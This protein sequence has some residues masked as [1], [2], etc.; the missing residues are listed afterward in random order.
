[1]K[2]YDEDGVCPKCGNDEISDEWHSIYC[3]RWDCPVG[4]EGAE[5]INRT[6]GRCHYIWAETVLDAEAAPTFSRRQA[7]G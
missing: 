7:D 1:M 2:S 5:H 4:A 6:C 3:S